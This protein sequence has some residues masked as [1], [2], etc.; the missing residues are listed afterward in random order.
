MQIIGKLSKKVA[1]TLN[2]EIKN[3][4]NIY[5]ANSNVNHIKEKHPKAYD[6]YF[7][8]IQ[9]IISH[10]DY[11]GLNPKDDSIEYVKEY[12]LNGEYVKVAVRISN[13]D[14]YFVRSLY[15]LN[16]RRVKDFLRKNKL[17]P[18]DKGK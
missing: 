11:V 6:K 12:I 8:D 2:I 1:E 13:N 15:V 10:P 7:N 9:K 16:S 5:I 4:I 17:K 3:D 14:K 18:L